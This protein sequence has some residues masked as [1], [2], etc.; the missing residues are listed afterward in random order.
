[1]NLRHKRA[2]QARA[3]ESANSLRASFYR[4]EAFALPSAGHAV[5]SSFAATIK[6]YVLRDQIGSQRCEGA[7]WHDGPLNSASPFKSSDALQLPMYNPGNLIHKVAVHGAAKK[8]PDK[9]L[10][11]SG[12]DESFELV[13]TSRRGS[14]FRQSG[15]QDV[16]KD[17]VLVR[18]VG[19]RYVLLKH[20]MGV[21]E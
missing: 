11:L 2:G 10:S 16:G 15:L 8:E 4:T 12:P 19:V 1:V 3:E 21:E 13:T 6:L 9:Q 5:L 20:A 18:V 17:G 7:L 14:L